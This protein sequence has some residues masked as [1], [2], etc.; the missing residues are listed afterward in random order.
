MALEEVQSGSVR[1][2]RSAIKYKSVSL[3]FIKPFTITV[4]FAYYEKNSIYDLFLY[5]LY[6]MFS[7]LTLCFNSLLSGI[8]RELESLSM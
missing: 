8:H 3:N 1:M 5:N 4:I 6:M 2:E 7:Y